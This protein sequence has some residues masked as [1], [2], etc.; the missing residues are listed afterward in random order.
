MCVCA[1]WDCKGTRL[2]KWLGKLACGVVWDGCRSAYKSCSWV[3]GCETLL[4]RDELA[5]GTCFLGTYNLLILSSQ[6]GQL[7]L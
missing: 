7:H 6:V 3:S 5:E 1:V 2:H 4:G